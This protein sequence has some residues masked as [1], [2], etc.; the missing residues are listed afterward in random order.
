MRKQV[1]EEFKENITHVACGHHHTLVV[2]EKGTIYF[3]GMGTQ[4]ERAT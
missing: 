2:D 1:N 4:G 3:F